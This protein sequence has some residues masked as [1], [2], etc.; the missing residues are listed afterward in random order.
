ME[1]SLVGKILLHK[2]DVTFAVTIGHQ[3]Y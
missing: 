3:A 2:T 1:A